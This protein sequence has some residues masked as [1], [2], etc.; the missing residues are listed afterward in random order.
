[1]QRTEKQT[2]NQ[3]VSST[4][5]SKIYNPMMCIQ[6]GARRIDGFDL[7]AVVTLLTHIATMQ[8]VGSRSYYLF[9]IIAILLC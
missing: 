9:L 8:F 6:S 3:A 4:F 5:Y 2:N 1:M 7:G